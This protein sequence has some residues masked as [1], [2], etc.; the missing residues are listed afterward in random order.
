MSE[1]ERALKTVA[2]PALAA[3]DITFAVL[4]AVTDLPNARG[5][6]TGK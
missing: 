5:E 6:Q 4:T 3:I 2:N 1:R